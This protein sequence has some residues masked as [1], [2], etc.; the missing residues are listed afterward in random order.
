M[1]L[2]YLETMEEYNLK[3]GDLSEDA[4]NGIEQ[5]NDVIKGIKLHES[6]GNT[7]SEKTF[8]KLR[9]LDKWVSYE[10]LDMVNDTDKNDDDLPHTSEEIMNEFEEEIDEAEDFYGDQEEGLKI[11]ADLKLAYE[12]GKKNISFD[13]LKSISRTAYYTIF[14]SYDASGENGLVTSNFSLLEI[15]ENVF[16]LEK[17]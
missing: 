11:D 17:K 6:R 4:Q 9:T 12:S 1:T 14:N 10:I 2:H 7:V 3:I 13:E 8:K 5:I 16:T 15:D